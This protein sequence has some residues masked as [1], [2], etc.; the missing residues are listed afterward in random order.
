MIIHNEIHKITLILIYYKVN[1]NQYLLDFINNC[2]KVYN[3]YQTMKNAS[4]IYHFIYD[5]TNIYK[6]FNSKII[7]DINY[8]NNESFNNIFHE[9]KKYIIRD[10][11]RLNDLDYYKRHGLKR[12]KGY[13]FYG[14]P[15]TGKTATVM[16]M[17]NYSNR[18]IVEIPL[19][20]I[21]SNNILIE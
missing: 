18:H 10:I 16:A 14:K 12:K 9:H 17:S 8:K 3:N 4:K 6:I 20:R 5:E 11:D 7:S 1:K 15:G 13:L 21:K 19:N 2:L